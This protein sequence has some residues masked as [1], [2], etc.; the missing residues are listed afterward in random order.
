MDSEQPENPAGAH[1]LRDG[2]IR[3]KHEFLHKLMG[4]IRCDT[5]DACHFERTA[6]T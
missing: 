4:G 3:E 5:R 6:A 2:D 1:F